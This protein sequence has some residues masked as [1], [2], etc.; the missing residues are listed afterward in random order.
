MFS[1]PLY[2]DPAVEHRRL[3]R[4]TSLSP[5]LTLSLAK[6]APSQNARLKMAGLGGAGG[7]GGLDDDDWGLSEGQ[8]AQLEQG[9]YRAIAERKASSSAASTAPAI[10]PLPHRALSPAATVSSP[11]R[12]EHPASRVSLESRF[13]K[14]RVSSVLLLFGRGIFWQFIV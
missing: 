10:S 7:W 13:G 9:A 5:P 4:P 3:R 2:R 6:T 11:L 1:F 8:Y 12:N 14:V